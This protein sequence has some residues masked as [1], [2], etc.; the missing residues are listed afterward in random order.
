MSVLLRTLEHVQQFFMLFFQIISRS[1]DVCGS[2]NT[3]P[4]NFEVD[5]STK[6][7][8]KMRASIFKMMKKKTTSLFYDFILLYLWVV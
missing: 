3:D 6:A 7:A 2:T 8:W 5:P 1:F 4:K